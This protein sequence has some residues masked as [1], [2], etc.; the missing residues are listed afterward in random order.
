MG[1]PQFTK[2]IGGGNGET[3]PQEPDGEI[4]TSQTV[5]RSESVEF[6]VADQDTNL[7]AGESET[8]LVKPPHGYVYDL[9]AW[10]FSTNTPENSTEG[11]HEIELRS[12]TAT[13]RVMKGVSSHDNHLVYRNGGWSFTSSESP[14]TEAAT[15]QMLRGLRAD[16]N[17]GFSFVY[18][19]D[20]DV[21]QTNGRSIRL[22]VRKL[23]VE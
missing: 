7:A 16:A 5:D 3:F 13:V 2:G 1:R 22:W 23:Q 18:R 10:R 4:Q 15:I 6:I 21:E 8:I 14:S 17:N 19:N 12:E 20:T 9:I 11:T